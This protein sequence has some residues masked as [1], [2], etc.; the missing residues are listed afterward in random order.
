MGTPAGTEAG[1]LGDEVEACEEEGEEE[2]SQEVTDQEIMVGLA[3][4]VLI[5]Y[6]LK[7]LLRIIEIVVFWPDE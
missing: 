7:A 3:V 6:A 5:Y 4:G 1:P 2:E